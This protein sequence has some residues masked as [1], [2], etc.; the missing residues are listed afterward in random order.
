M[1]YLTHRMDVLPYEYTNDYP[2]GSINDFLTKV[3]VA[4]LVAMLYTPRLHEK[5]GHCR[6]MGLWGALSE[7]V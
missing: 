3:G 5:S 1:V 7:G 6:R 2:D 4:S